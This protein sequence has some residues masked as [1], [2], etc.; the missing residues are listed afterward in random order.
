MY[1][2]AQASEEVKVLLGLGNTNY[3]TQGKVYFD[4]LKVASISKE[5]YSK[6][7]AND[8]TLVS[9]VIASTTSNNNENNSNSSTST[10]SDI[11][12]FALF[13]SIILIIALG[14]A[15]A[16]YMIRRIP[17]KKIAKVEKS[18]YNKSPK[19]IDKKA[20]KQELKLSR[21]EKVAKLKEE[22]TQLKT[23]HEKLQTEYEKATNDEENISKKEQLYKA[24]T[25]KINKL[26]SQIEY[27]ESAL[28]YAQDTVN[29]RT[30]EN[31]EIKKRQK[32]ADEEFEK[33]KKQEVEKALAN[34]IDTKTNKKNNS[35]KLK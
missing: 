5:D 13:S 32:E 15:I 31:L 27:I 17:K 7:K 21:E 19:E 22:L 14:L 28:V 4:D 2:L 8:T 1:V 11:N 12:F 24:H 30:M 9:K 20:V 34:D 16:G 29:I 35:K 23:E 6:V 3:S 10:P 33:L 26:N 25:K 18:L